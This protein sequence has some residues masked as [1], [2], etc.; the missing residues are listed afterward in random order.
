MSHDRKGQSQQRK[1]E[2][3]TNKTK[4]QKL[5]R[6]ET[7]IKCTVLQTELDRVFPSEKS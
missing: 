4:S 6:S 5:S 3:H 2:T 7:R 1:Y